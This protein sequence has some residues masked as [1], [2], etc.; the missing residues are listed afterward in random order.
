MQH[1]PISKLCSV[2]QRDDD[3][4]VRCLRELLAERVRYSER[5]PFHLMPHISNLIMLALILVTPISHLQQL[6]IL[7]DELMVLI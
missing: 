2:N 6:R 4:S 7:R 5:F 3:D 1:A